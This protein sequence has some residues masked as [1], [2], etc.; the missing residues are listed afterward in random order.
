[1][2]GPP[3]DATADGAIGAGDGYGRAVEFIRQNQLKG[4]LAT[5]FDFGSYAEW[6]L[7]PQCKILIDGRYEEVFPDDVIELAMRLSVRQGAWWEV[8]DRFP[9][10]IVVL[11]KQ[12]YSLADLPSLRGWKPVYQDHVVA[13]RRCQRFTVRCGGAID[14][15]APRVKENVHR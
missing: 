12:G 10:D 8:L 6:K 7:Y 2:V 11:P 1:M 3:S 14:K 15:A 13:L 5:A 4:N 9:S